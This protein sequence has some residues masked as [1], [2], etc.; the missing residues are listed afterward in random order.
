MVVEFITIAVFVYGGGIYYHRCFCLWW[1]NL[2]P[3]LFLF[4][5]VEFITIAVFV[6]FSFLLRN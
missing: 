3:S 4:M 2:L 6:Y 1:W 5:V